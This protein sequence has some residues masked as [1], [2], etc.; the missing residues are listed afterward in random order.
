MARRDPLATSDYLE[1]PVL[2]V[3]SQD[4]TSEAGLGP[5]QPVTIGRDPSNDIVLA[6]SFVSK[7]HAVVRYAAGECVVEDLQSA[8]GT[9]VNGQPIA[10]SV[11]R[12]GDRVEIGDYTLEVVD[13]GTGR[14]GARPGKAA[15]QSSKVLR[16]AIT[17]TATMVVMLV[18]LLLLVPLEDESAAPA[19]RPGSERGERVLLPPTPIETPD[20]SLVGPV[21]A[22]AKVAGVGEADALFDEGSLQLRVGRLRDAV[23]LFSAVLARSPGHQAAASRLSEARTQLEE[24][25]ERLQAEADRAFAQL[26]FADA[27]LDWEGVQGLVEPD[28][29]RYAAAAA[30]AARARERMPRP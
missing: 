7:Q 30:A 23:H 25:V 2:V 22:R 24:E 29:P 3:T 5:G 11:V 6:S 14:R 17:A 18:M 21:L 28:D 15:P 16:L 10:V 13:R 8:N 12:V 27:I 4:G 26:R 1:K 19:T 20:P 9:K